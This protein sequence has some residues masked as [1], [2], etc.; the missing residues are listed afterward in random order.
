MLA[1]PKDPKDLKGFRDFFTTIRSQACSLAA[2]YEGPLK[3]VWDDLVAKYDAVLASLPKD[4]DGN[5][6]VASSLDCLFSSL[7]SS[8]ACASSLSLE[9]SKARTQTASAVDAEITRRITAG[10][11]LPKDQL[12]PKIETAVQEKV[13]AGDLV[14]KTTVTQLCSSAKDNGIIEGEKKVRAEMEAEKNRAALIGTRKAALTTAGIA[15]P[16]SEFEKLLLGGTDEEFT[17]AKTL[18]E[19]RKAAFQTAGIN[20]SED[21]MSSLWLPKDQFATFEKTVANIPSLKLAAEPLAR[22]TGGTEQ[23]PLIV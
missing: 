5:W 9:L 16:A 4:T 23:K 20:L 12:T 13:T 14:P 11:L 3:Q 21:L 7:V 8:N 19:T 22:G 2:T 1:I 10:D 15:L 18:F 6:S 17:A